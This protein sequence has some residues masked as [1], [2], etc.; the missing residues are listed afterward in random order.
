MREYSVPVLVRCPPLRQPDRHG[1]PARRRGAGRRRP[2]PQDRRRLDRRHRE[3]VPRPGRRG[4]QG[5]DRGR[6]RAGR[7]GGPDVAH[8]LRVDRDRL[9]RS[10]PP[11]P[12]PCRSTRPPPPTRSSG[13]SPTAARR[14]CSWSWT[15]HEETVRES[16]SELPELKDVWRIESGALDELTASGAGVSDETL[17]ERRRARGG[18]DLA[19]IVYT[20][21]TTGRPKGCR[22]T[23]DN[24]CS[25]PETWRGRPWRR[26]SPGRAGP[27]CCSCRSRT[28]RPHHRG[29]AA[30]RRARSSRTRRT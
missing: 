1:V 24:L 9:S 23:H 20:S 2:A 18:A 19:T 4:G 27:R 28:L 3:G 10:G 6:H 25:P 12:S 29:R 21:G 16:A 13:S 11:A 30:S 8:P 5:A 14:P 15:S 17:A 7:P 22:L 26:S